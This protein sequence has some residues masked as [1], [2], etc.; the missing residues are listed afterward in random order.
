MRFVFGEFALEPEART[1]RQRGERV[2]IEPKV[3]DLLVYLIEHRERVVPADE[4]LDALWPGVSVTPGALNR[5]VLKARQA[6]G[7]DGEHQTMLRTE[8]GRGFRF[9]ANVS[10]DQDPEPLPPTPTRSPKRLAAASGLA[11]LL[12]VAAAVWLLNR[13]LT[14]SA[15]ARSVAV[16]PFVNMSQDAVAEP[17]TAG[18]YDDI[19]T[20]IS[21]IRDLKVIARTTMERLDPDLGIQ[22][23]G[24]KLGVAAVLE[25]GVQRVG[26]R[27]RINVQ[28]NDCETEAHLWAETY[29][30]EL[31][32]ANIFAIQSEIAQSVADALQAELSPEEQDRIVD[33]P[34]ENLAAYEAYLLGRKRMAELTI[35]A[36]VESTD[37]FQRAIELDPNYALAYVGLADSY[38]HQA[39]WGRAPRSETLD[40]A[41]V[42]VEKALALDDRLGEAYNSLGGIKDVRGDVEGAEAAYQRAL[43]LNPNYATTYHWYGVLLLRKS[44]RAEEALPMF[45][46][47]AELDPLSGMILTDLAADLESLGRFEEALAWFERSIEIDPMLDGIN[48]RIGFHH[49]SVTGKLDQ[50]VVW[51]RRAVSIDPEQPF[52]ATTLGAIYLDLGDPDKAEY[53]FERS[54]ALR[55][56]RSAAEIEMSFLHLYR[57]D[58]PAAV[59]Q[60]R[61]ARAVFPG[62][63]EALL[64]LRNHELSLGRY[65]E[66]RTLFEKNNPDLL[67]DG[68]PEVGWMNWVDAVNLASVLFKTGEKERANLL[69]EKSLQHIR[70][71]PRLGINGYSM[72]DVDIFAMQGQKQKALAALRQAVD[73]GWRRYWWYNLKY[74][75]DLVSLHDEPEYQAI[76]AE[77]ETDMASQLAH[78]REMERRGEL[79]AIPQIEVS[80]H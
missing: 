56:E 21:K 23:I 68:D 77:I 47:A 37:H 59:E 46:R 61:K 54:I 70:T 65:A 75:P 57:G 11:A 49:W 78:V 6:V 41:Q 58:E 15:P 38:V 39:E 74:E 31:T 66:A 62:N 12:L 5:A 16:L 14:E 17:F 76:V 55:P 52:F 27:V 44:G 67:S 10:V 8:H 51:F 30:R 7:D 33:A 60:A 18:I 32:A 69:L 79:A 2:P 9:V 4:L 71:K 19:L 35:A 64:L 43:E 48:G 24:S 20:H 72:F 42:A 13:P 53:W 34:T 26:D 73:E 63:S 50:A 25:G 40:K 36:V 29:D 1:L 80:L 22:E 3:F 28:L 45:L